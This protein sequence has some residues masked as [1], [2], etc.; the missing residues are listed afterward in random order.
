MDRFGVQINKTSRNTVLCMTT[1]G[2]TRSSVAYL[3]E[4]LVTIARELDAQVADMN[5]A[6]RTAHK[7]AVLQLTAPSAPLP[8]FSGFHPSFQDG[9]GQPTPEGDVRRAFYLCYDDSHCEYLTADEV[10]QR[11]EDGQQVVS[12]TYVTPYPPG[13][14]V[15]VPGQLFSKQI[16]SFMRSLDTPEIH[17]YR[18][19]LGYRVYVGEALE[20]AKTALPEPPIR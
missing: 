6:E 13:F 12:A 5:P 19:G 7:R 8:D 18:P 4:V 11:V 9:D 1:I 20:P 10:E 2:T 16:L 15:L 14:P 17:G 3:I